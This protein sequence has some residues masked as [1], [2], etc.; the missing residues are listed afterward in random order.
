[1][2]R[3]RASSPLVAV[4]DVAGDEDPGAATISEV[5]PKRTGTHSLE[6]N[7]RHHRDLLAM[8]KEMV[9]FS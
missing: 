9:R 8:K 5:S 4:R 7:G 2:K 1:M 6:K 3:T